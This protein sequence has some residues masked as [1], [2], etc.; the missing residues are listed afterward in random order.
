MLVNSFEVIEFPLKCI[1]QCSLPTTAHTHWPYAAEAN[2]K[3]TVLYCEFQMRETHNATALND[4]SVTPLL[5]NQQNTR[6]CSTQDSFKPFSNPEADRAFMQI[7]LHG[8]RHQHRYNSIS[9]SLIA[10]QSLRHCAAGRDGQA[11]GH[12]IVCT[13]R[14]R[15]CGR[16]GS[17]TTSAGRQGSSAARESSARGPPG[18][19]P[20]PAWWLAP[21]PGW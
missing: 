2:G 7:H 8:P 12:T 14:N 13:P 11:A 19:L 10:N 16:V 3:H 21:L 5:L 15:Q 18:C 4:L 1:S 20:A 9:D 6:G 17:V